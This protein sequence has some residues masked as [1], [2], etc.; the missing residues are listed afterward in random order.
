MLR[1]IVIFVLS[2][3]IGGCAMTGGF[4]MTGSMDNLEKSGYSAEIGFKKEF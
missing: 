4:K 2:L 3:A 1:R